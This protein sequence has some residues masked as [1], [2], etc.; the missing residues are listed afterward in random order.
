MDIVKLH[1]SKKNY[2]MFMIYFLFFPSDAL[3]CIFNCYF[4][5]NKSING[6]RQLVYFKIITGKT[7]GKLSWISK[8]PLQRNDLAA[9][10]KSEAN[11]LFDL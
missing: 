11:Y 7:L 4:N 8:I 9:I 3:Y 2:I 1:L 10:P 6:I 5:K